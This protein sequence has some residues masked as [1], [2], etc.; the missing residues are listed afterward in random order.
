MPCRSQE[1]KPDSTPYS[2]N[3][4]RRVPIPLIP[5]VK[6]ELHRLQKEGVIAPI[7]EATEWCSPMVPVVKPNKDVRICVDLK[8]LNQAVVRE[9]Y[10]PYF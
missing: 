10:S 5:K 8:R 1:N 6:A 3:V 4:A 7:T 9:V 2:V